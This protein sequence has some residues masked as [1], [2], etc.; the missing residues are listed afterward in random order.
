VSFATGVIALSL[1][2]VAY[3]TLGGLRAVAW[4]DVLQGLI[5]MVACVAIFFA[6][7]LHY[8]TPGQSA[9]RLLEVAPDKWGPP[10]TGGKLGWASTLLLVT[11]GVSIYPHAIQ[12][13]YAARSARVLRRS[14]QWMLVMPFL[15]TLLM[16][17]VGLVGAAHFPDL[18]TDQS[19]QVVLI[20]LQDLARAVPAV[21]ILIVVLVCALI[22]AIM[23][24]V[25]S[26]LLAISSLVTQDLYA[27]YRP[28][29][30][31]ATLARLGKGFSWL[32]MALLVILALWLPQTLWR[33]T[34]IKLE[35]LCQMAPAIF[36]GLHVRRVDARSVG[37][38]LAA[39][40]TLTLVLLL[41]EQVSLPVTAKP[42]GVHAGIWGLLLNGI[43]VLTL[44]GRHPQSVEG[45]AP[46]SLGVS[47]V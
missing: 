37:L 20:V 22:A 10:S 38:G 27:L 8:G 14:M 24:T 32:L 11:F 29:G 45:A 43:L 3:E 17:G 15:T 42:L 25:D 18:T 33:L 1:L 5:L 40:L 47:S 44:S 13:I 16:V 36:L 34:E 23:S 39:G 28:G 31:Q 12:R 9:A 19:E 30:D 35:V 26:A 7:G 4:T 41:G 2:M 21:R 6:I 46:G